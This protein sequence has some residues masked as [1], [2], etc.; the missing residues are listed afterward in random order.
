MKTSP[1][2]SQIKMPHKKCI[3]YCFVILFLFGKLVACAPRTVLPTIVAQ[4]TTT[5]KESEI[6]YTPRP[7]GAEEP[8]PT[9][10]PPARLASTPAINRAGSAR[11]PTYKPTTLESPTP[12]PTLTTNQTLEKI[13]P[14]CP[15]PKSLM[16]HTAYGARRMEELAQEILA[17]GLRTRTYQDVIDSLLLGECPGKDTIIISIDDL[18]TNWLRKDFRDMIQVFL[19]HNLVLVVGTVVQGPQNSVIWDYLRDLEA[20]RI[21]VASHTVSHYQLSALTDEAIQEE[22][23]GSYK[24]ICENLAKCPVSIIL[25]FGDGGEDRRVTAAAK[26]YTFIVGIAGG[27]SFLGSPP[28]YVG[29]IPP[30]NG[31]QRLTMRLLENSFDQ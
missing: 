16:L 28:Y 4:P 26:E 30:D 8:V 1:L 27:H 3:Y 19:D 12:L 15:T 6:V 22:I 18:G 13:Q 9:E 5:P 17:H 29:R 10:N 23:A 2:S 11:T 7:S 21:E 24:V 25:P 20:T 31:D 14:D